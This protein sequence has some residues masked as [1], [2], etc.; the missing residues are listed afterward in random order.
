MAAREEE[1]P[2]ISEE[3]VSILSPI[4]FDGPVVRVPETPSNSQEALMPETP[5]TS[6]RDASASS[7]FVPETPASQLPN[8][9]NCDISVIL[10]LPEIPTFECMPCKKKFKNRATLRSHQRRKHELDFNISCELCNM[11]FFNTELLKEHRAKLHKQKG[12]CRCKTC[13]KVLNSYRGM[14]EHVKSHSEEV[15]KCTECDKFFNSKQALRRH[16]KTHDKEFICELCDKQFATKFQLKVHG[17]VHQV[18][19]EMYRCDQC[20]YQSRWYSCVKRDVTKVHCRS[21]PFICDN[22]GHSFKDKY[23]LK[24]HISNVKCNVPKMNKQWEDL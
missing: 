19:P 21:R 18:N 1:K 13:F 23:N 4:L 15:H 14:R 2:L 7:M 12:L 22:C 10:N 8:L 9:E 20:Q 11:S 24:R 3:D 5:C 17:S 16:M 6:Q